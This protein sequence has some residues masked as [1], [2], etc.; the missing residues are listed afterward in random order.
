MLGLRGQKTVIGENHKAK[1]VGTRR[2]S[3]RSWPATSRSDDW[4]EY[5]I[6]ADGFQFMQKI[7]GVTSCRT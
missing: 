7:N 1:V 4:N 3:R 5:T 2:R 6:I